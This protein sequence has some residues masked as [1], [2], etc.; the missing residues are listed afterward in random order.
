MDHLDLEL[1]SLQLFQLFLVKSS[2][3]VSSSF[4]VV[5][6]SAPAIGPV[7]TGRG[8]LDGPPQELMQRLDREGSP[9]APLAPRL[10]G[11]NT[12]RSQQH[13]SGTASRERAELAELAELGAWTWRLGTGGRG[14]GMSRELLGVR[15][16]MFE[17]GWQWGVFWFTKR[18]ARHFGT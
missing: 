10:L 3:G 17:L 12:F 14:A 8:A 16:S 11:R 2:P 13:Y 7:S 9:V 4:V 5:H 15:L 18:R 6:A 1:F